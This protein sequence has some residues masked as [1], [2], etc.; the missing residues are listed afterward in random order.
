MAVETLDVG[1]LAIKLQKKNRQS[2][3]DTEDYSI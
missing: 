2:L 1:I 3:A